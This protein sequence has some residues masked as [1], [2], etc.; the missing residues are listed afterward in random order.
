MRLLRILVGVA[1]SLAILAGLVIGV[2]KGEAPAAEAS[3]AQQGDWGGKWWGNYF[4]FWDFYPS[5][6]WPNWGAAPFRDH[7]LRFRVCVSHGNEAG[8]A[9]W[10]WTQRFGFNEESELTATRET[11]CGVSSDALFWVT[12]DQNVT[13]ACGSGF[14]ACFDPFTPKWDSYVGR[15]EVEVAIIYSRQSWMDTHSQGWNIHL[16][17][18]ELGHGMGLRHHSACAPYVMENGLCSGYWVET[19]DVVTARCVYGYAC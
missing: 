12:S 1:I 6:D 9:A 14:I 10:D 4:T 11:N 5:N 13:E 3:H 19:P 7:D 16:F 8:Y 17:E 2:P 15:W 18:H